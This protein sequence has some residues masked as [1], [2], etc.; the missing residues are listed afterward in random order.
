MLRYFP[1]QCKLQ[2]YAKKAQGIKAHCSSCV[3]HLVCRE[4]WD[5]VKCVSSR[6]SNKQSVKGL[7]STETNS[8]CVHNT[9]RH[10]KLNQCPETI[11]VF[12]GEIFPPKPVKHK[13][14]WSSQ[15]QSPVKKS[16]DFMYSLQ[17][18]HGRIQTGQFARNWFLLC[19]KIK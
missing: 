16:S 13:F 17:K 2:S 4:V 3:F 9:H 15:S 1:S 8:L 6:I 12:T 11:I 18:N 10:H 5:C 14:H 19:K 7:G